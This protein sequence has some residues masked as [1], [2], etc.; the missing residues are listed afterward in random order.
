MSS[1]THFIIQKH[2]H[3]FSLTKNLA[4][5]LTVSLRILCGKVLKFIAPLFDDLY[6][7]KLSHITLNVS[8]LKI[9]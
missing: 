2:T 8:S 9:V 5:V 3:S 4:L 6:A 1:R 7:L